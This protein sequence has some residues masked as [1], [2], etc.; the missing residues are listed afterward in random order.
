MREKSVFATAV[1]LSFFV[2]II[3]TVAV[4]YYL[5]ISGRTIK[6]EVKNVNV[7]ETNT[8][9]SGVEKVY[10]AVLYVESYEDSR[11]ISTGTGFI[12]KK[13]DKFGY[14]ITNHHVIDGA[15]KV[16]VV[17]TAG[18]IVD[19]TILGSDEFADIAVLSVDVNT[20]LQ[21]AKIGAS[22]ELNL[23]D[24]LFTV[25]SPL[26]KTY[27]GTV[28]KGILSGKDRTVEVDLADK[29][30]FMME[31]LQTDAAINPGNSGGPLC[32]I[33]GEVVGINSLK[34]V[35]DEI[36]SMGFAIPVE[37]AMATVDRLEKGEE[38][39]RP[40]LGV[41]LLDLDDYGQLNYYR[42]D[43]DD[44]V[45]QGAVIATVSNDSPAKVADLRPGDVI[46]EIDGTAIK[47][48]A[49]LRF[50]LYKYAVGDTIKIKYNRGGK[51]STKDVLLNKSL[52]DK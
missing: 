1:I 2:G 31:V 19:A 7:T 27:M 40:L 44:S 45:N 50:V 20:V 9:K 8:I 28:T 14:L 51:E 25:G 11:L 30:T 16:Q 3:G 26:G 34:L 21:V 4:F 18:E 10:D 6:E 47:S 29:G 52:E 38:I 23:G 41:E 13:D 24:S 32:D 36:E 12:Y 33:N 5:P 22:T 15:N 49:H 35:K 39:K 42:I 43:I 37:L 46:T 17:N 48:V